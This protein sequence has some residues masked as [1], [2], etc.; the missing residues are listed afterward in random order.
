MRREQRLGDA[1]RARRIAALDDELLD[2]CGPLWF[3]ELPPQE[4][5]AEDY[6]LLVH[7]LMRLALARQRFTFVTALM[8][9]VSA[10]SAS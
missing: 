4:G 7:E 1:G 9:A 10:C 2:L 8:R 5:P 3:A 6:R